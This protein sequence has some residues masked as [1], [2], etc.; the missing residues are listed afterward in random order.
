[1]KRNRRN[2][3]H[4]TTVR[5]KPESPFSI[6]RIVF[7][8]SRAHLSLRDTASLGH[9]L[10]EGDVER[11]Q[12]RVLAVQAA[13]AR[14]FVFDPLNTVLYFVLIRVHSWFLILE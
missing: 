12:E 2:T 9:C 8:S 5:T 1:M 13:R 3:G 14:F 7:R 11:K 10:A 4:A 6:R